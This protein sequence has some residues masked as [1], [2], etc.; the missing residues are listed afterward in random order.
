MTKFQWQ[1][2]TMT[3]H[4]L[5]LAKAFNTLDHSSYKN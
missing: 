2:I 4:F 5:D 3:M 1:W